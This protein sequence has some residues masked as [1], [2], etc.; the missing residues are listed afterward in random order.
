[1][2]VSVCFGGVGVISLF[3]MAPKCSA[4]VLSDVSNCKKA[5]MCLMEKI[6]VLAKL[7]SGVSYMLLAMSLLLMNQQ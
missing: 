4:E 3:K 6:C 2:C 1:M 7:C 5:G